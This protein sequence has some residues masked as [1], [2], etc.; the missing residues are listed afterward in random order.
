MRSGLPNIPPMCLTGIQSE[1]DGVWVCS[2]V[3]G[4]RVVG[5]WR[6]RGRSVRVWCE[7]GD[8]GEGGWRVEVVVEEERGVRWSGGAGAR[9]GP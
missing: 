8:R 3:P 6:Q 7:D 4:A 9:D 1:N 2:E 5:R